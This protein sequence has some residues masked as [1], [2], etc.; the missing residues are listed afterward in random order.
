MWH[1]NELA[2]RGLFKTLPLATK[3][4]LFQLSFDAQSSLDQDGKKWPNR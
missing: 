3:A 2:R 4:R 1:D